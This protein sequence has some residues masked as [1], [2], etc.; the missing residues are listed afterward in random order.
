[1]SKAGKK[2]IPFIPLIYCVLIAA[3]VIYAALFTDFRDVL[4]NYPGEHY[5]VLTDGW[6]D[7]NLAPVRLTEVASQAS[8]RETMQIRHVLP[9]GILAGETLNICSHNLFFKV[10]VDN[11]PIYDF[12][13]R[14]NLTGYGTGDVYHTISLSPED[15]GKDVMIEITL[16]NSSEIGGR[17][18][19]IVICTPNLFHYLLFRERGGTFLMSPLII[20]LGLVIILLNFSLKKENHHG[21]D[22]LSLGISVILIGGW[23]LIE[24]NILQMLLGMPGALRMLD[25]TL[26][27]LMSYPIVRFTNSITKKRNPFYAKLAF[28][29]MVVTLSALLMA[30]FV[31]GIDMHL[32]MN[33]LLLSYL[34]TI[35]LVGYILTKNHFY[36]KKRGISE[37]LRY[38]YIGA[39]FLL[40]GGLIDAAAY[41]MQG[42]EKSNNGNFLCA[43]LAIFILSMFLQILIWLVKERR[44]NR[45]DSFMNSLM[46]HA[47]SG[48]SAEATITQMLEYLGTELHPGRVYIYEE[49]EP[50]VYHNSY[51][52]L[53]GSGIQPVGTLADITDRDVVEDY[54]YPRFR[55]EG[56][57][58]IRDREQIKNDCPTLYRAMCEHNLFVMVV[59]PIR[60]GDEYIG[61][62][63]VSDPPIAKIED[64]T[65]F[66]P[67][68]EYF[69]SETIRRRGTERT[70]I[71]YGYYDQMTGV[72]NRRAMQEFEES[73]LDSSAPYG[74]IMCDINGLKT[75]N[76]NEGHKAGDKL[77]KDVANALT[78][79]FGHD[80]VFRVGGDEFAAY[81][82][83]DTEEAFLASFEKLK[84]AIEGRGRSASLG[85][86]FCPEGDPDYDHVKKEADKKMYQDKNRF[87]SG[88]PDRRNC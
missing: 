84:A 58:V 45:R 17:I 37:G 20:L 72:K 86:V 46:Q 41:I 6:V 10:Y 25:Y 79:V 8:G 30:R 24:S 42:K 60:I 15:A 85:Y 66:M 64:I 78:E 31:F 3:L 81:V 48:E 16:V 70:L 51:G 68:L 40:T 63:C 22:L 4:A 26:L 44:T 36:C 14:Q 21:Y 76:D 56:S 12:P 61:F 19:E 82:L 65:D 75:L 2:R 34:F 62:L 80:T 49:Q 28:L 27:P 52:W 39:A 69:V 1:M 23:T 33:G 47:I 35:I 13:P 53:A 83:S 29:M 77:I 54:Y 7:E 50:G 11:M 38:F 18:P 43:G 74:F 57:V 59:A 67:V 71:N 32:L 88:H 5:Q 9:E 55:K 87:Y 73:E